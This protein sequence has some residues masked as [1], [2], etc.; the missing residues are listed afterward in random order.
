MNKTSHTDGP[1]EGDDGYNQSLNPNSNDLTP[2]EGFNGLG[3]AGDPEKP[4]LLAT[5]VGKG[6][7]ELVRT[8]CDDS[9]S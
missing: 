6:A 7:D 9:N 1:A 5:V 8:R 2:N 4:P 3:F